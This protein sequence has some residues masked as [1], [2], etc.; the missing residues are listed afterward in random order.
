MNENWSSKQ[1]KDQLDHRQA[2][3]KVK[4]EKILP[5]EEAKYGQCIVPGH[6]QVYPTETELELGKVK[7][8]EVMMNESP[9][10][11]DYWFCETCQEYFI[12]ECALHGCPIF[13]TDTPIPVGTPDRAALT[14]PAGV[15]VVKEPGGEIDVRCLDAII[16][17]GRIFGPYE[18]EV[19]Q[20]D[21]SSGFFSWLI[22]GKNNTYKSIDGTDETKANWMRYVVISREENEQN[23]MAFQHNEKIYFRVC[24]DI[25]PG[26]RLR[27]WYSDDYMKRLHA[28]TQDTVDRSLLTA[29]SKC[30]KASLGR[31]S[32]EKFTGNPGT[33]RKPGI[34]NKE[35]IERLENTNLNKGGKRGNKD[36]DSSPSPKKKK[37][38]QLFK[39]SHDSPVDTS[40]EKLGYPVSGRG[41]YE[42]VYS[43]K[44]TSNLQITTS[45]PVPQKP[46]FVGRSGQE[47]E[48]NK[49]TTAQAKYPSPVDSHFPARQRLKHQD[50]DTFNRPGTSSQQSALSLSSTRVEVDSRPQQRVNEKHLNS[51]FL[52]NTEESSGVLPPE[53]SGGR[54]VGV[55]EEDLPKSQPSS[56]CPNCVILQEKIRQLQEE[57]DRL[58]SNLPVPSV[59]TFAF[60]E[61]LVQY[62]RLHLLQSDVGEERGTLIPEVP[63]HQ[64]QPLK[65]KVQHHYSQHHSHHPPMQLHLQQQYQIQH[66]EEQQPVDQEGPEP[67]QTQ[68]KCS[69]Q[70]LKVEQCDEIPA[71]H[72]SQQYYPEQPK[73]QY[74]QK[75]HKEQFCEVPQNNSQCQQQLVVE[76]HPLNSNQLTQLQQQSPHQLTLLQQQSSHQLP[77]L[78]QSTHQLPQLQQQSTHQLPQ[79][80]QQSTHQLPQLQQQSPHQL[81]QLQQ[82]SPH[83]LPQLQQQSPHQLPQ[84]QQQSP[85]QL[86]QLQQQS[87]HQLPQ[88]QQQSPHQ[89]PQIQQ[90]SP[91]QL[92]QPQQQVPDQ[93]T[94]LWQQDDLQPLPPAP[95]RP[96]H[97]LHHQLPQYQCP[98]LQEPPHLQHR[99]QPSTFKDICRNLK[100]VAARKRMRQSQPSEGVQPGSGIS[101]CCLNLNSISPAERSDPSKLTRALLE[102]FYTEQHLASHCARGKG[103]NSGFNMSR[104]ALDPDVV[105]AIKAYVQLKFTYVTDK[106]FYAMVNSKCS[107]SRK[108]IRYILGVR[109]RTEDAP[110]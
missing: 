90:S 12:D 102:Y 85:H 35:D 44:Q 68:Q 36:G 14:V 93:K 5:E 60:L 19:C 63:D 6:T 106:A 37:L 15:A 80:Q 92:P 54:H 8:E 107:D 38:E 55:V 40:R 67:Q 28:T 88:L 57:L 108:K 46:Q 21:K 30:K 17:R 29:E 4:I 62:Y 82:Q 20:T 59:A 49:L 83:Q 104:P 86:P 31:H 65:N 41:P 7:G 51:G 101:V 56:Y 25:R 98:S 105:D 95:P 69:E 64:Q 16:P 2:G 13:V 53:T 43:M 70:E 10:Q 110:N 103:K 61:N 11:Y 26:E 18:G 96:Q 66:P 45:S 42:H 71:Q 24:R 22:L 97:P 73:Q 91:H 9:E 39:S 77:Q 3:V 72:H 94:F 48:I 109:D 58:K 78:Q 34:L 87:P 33:S 50:G 89:L 76:H 84:L 1:I 52:Q 32:T 99:L 75:N 79:L 74:Q 27:I 23:L 100:A 81:P 47:H